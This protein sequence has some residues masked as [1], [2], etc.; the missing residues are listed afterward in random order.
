MTHKNQPFSYFVDV[1]A[2]VGGLP[3]VIG[4]GGPL[5]QDGNELYVGSSRPIEEIADWCG[6]TMLRY[7]PGG[8]L[9]P[10]FGTDGIVTKQIGNCNSLAGEYFAAGGALQSTH[11][12]IVGGAYSDIPP[13]TFGFLMRFDPDGLELVRE[14]QYTPMG[15]AEILPDDKV[16]VDE[17]SG[18]PWWTPYWSYRN[19]DLSGIGSI[20]P[21]GSI[22]LPSGG[23]LYAGE[24]RVR[25]PRN[26][27][28][29]RHAPDG[30]LDTGFGGDGFV[31]IDVGGDDRSPAVDPQGDGSLVV[32]GLSSACASG[33]FSVVV[34]TD[35]SYPTPGCDP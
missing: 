27:V 17:N 23:V 19:P 18:S 24:D 12:I 8:D 35:G 25:S 16:I 15:I 13:D 2:V 20:V 10:G 9:D 7:L 14:D 34:D 29:V 11:H 6:F 22:A 26:I 1:N 21:A 30:N 3:D 4:A 5:L 33:S 31:V 32:T 28:L